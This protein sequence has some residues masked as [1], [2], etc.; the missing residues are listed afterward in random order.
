V[1]LLA[2]GLLREYIGLLPWRRS[3]RGNRKT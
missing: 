1:A 3:K 2:T